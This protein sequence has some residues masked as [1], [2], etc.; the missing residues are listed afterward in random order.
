MC[1]PADQTRDRDQRQ[2]QTKFLPVCQVTSLHLLALKSSRRYISVSI[3]FG[4]DSLICVGSF[5]T[6]FAEGKLVDAISN[7]NHICSYNYLSVDF[8]M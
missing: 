7:T 4:I 3:P 8:Y 2:I 1:F 6:E 5:T